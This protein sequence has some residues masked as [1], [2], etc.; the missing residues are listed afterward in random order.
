MQV[1][2][3]ASPPPLQTPLPRAP[4]RVKIVSFLFPLRKIGV[5]AV[6][7]KESSAAAEL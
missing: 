2:D 5:A 4:Y 7:Q 6:F 1:A 3:T